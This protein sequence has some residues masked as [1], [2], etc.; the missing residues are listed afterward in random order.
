VVIRKPTDLKLGKIPALGNRG[1][2]R[3]TD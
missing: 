2:V 3:L 1:D